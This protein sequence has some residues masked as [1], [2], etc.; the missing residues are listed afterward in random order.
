LHVFIG[1]H[2]L[3]GDGLGLDIINY[4]LVEKGHTEMEAFSQ[5]QVMEA[6]QSGKN[7]SLVTRLDWLKWSTCENALTCEKEPSSS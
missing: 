4:R 3:N 5:L 2:A 1:S 6:G 7:E